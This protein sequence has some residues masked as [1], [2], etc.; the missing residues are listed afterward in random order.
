MEIQGTLGTAI[1]QLQTQMNMQNATESKMGIAAG[2][3]PVFSLAGANT[4]LT[5]YNVA[6]LNM[7]WM[8]LEVGLLTIV[9]WMDNNTY[10]W[11]SASIWDGSNEV[12]LVYITA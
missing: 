1:K 12:G 6:G 10:G 9:D 2:S 7:T 5:A 3:G 4:K 8:E 11:G